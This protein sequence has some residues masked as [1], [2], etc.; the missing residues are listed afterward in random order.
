MTM[1]Q[2]LCRMDKE[3]CLHMF[4]VNLD[5]KVTLEIYESGGILMHSAVVH[6]VSEFPNFLIL[7]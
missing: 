3:L 1:Q 5:M 6:S 4:H 7:S 2:I